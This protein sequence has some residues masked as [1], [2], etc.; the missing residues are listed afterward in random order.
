MVLFFRLYLGIETVH[1]SFVAT[2]GKDGHGLKSWGNGFNQVKM[3]QVRKS[4]KKL[5]LVFS[6][7]I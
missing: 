4:P 7:E 5:R 3:L 6:D 1:L 2:D